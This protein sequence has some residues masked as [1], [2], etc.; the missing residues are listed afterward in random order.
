MDSNQHFNAYSLLLERTS[1]R[2]KQYAQTQFKLQK[3]G[4][5]VDQWI[6]LKKLNE[7]SGCSQSDLAE[8]VNKDAPTLTRIIDLLVDKGLLQRNLDTEDRRKFVV[9]LTTEGTQKVQD[10]SPKIDL[11]RQQAWKNMTQADF[12]HFKEILEKIYKNLE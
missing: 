1:K 10:I 12:E 7:V 4:I 3:F 11:I 5:T 8:L 2:I 9:C 6:V